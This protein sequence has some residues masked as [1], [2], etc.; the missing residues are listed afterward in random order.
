MPALVVITASLG[1]YRYV[2]RYILVTWSVV[3]FRCGERRSGGTVALLQGRLCIINGLESIKSDQWRDC[4]SPR[5]GGTWRRAVWTASAAVV[6]AA[7]STPVTAANRP[8]G[9]HWSDLWLP[10]GATD[11]TRWLLVADGRRP[12]ERSQLP[13]AATTTKRRDGRFT[14]T[15][16]FVVEVPRDTCDVI[17]ADDV[18][19]DVTRV[20]DVGHD[21]HV[22]QATQSTSGIH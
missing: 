8:A 5:C 9:R 18:T 7:S 14:G 4:Q 16:C 22:T 6:P 12:S 1:R 19:C 17:A 11:C 3:G 2:G 10:A 21:R 15:R 13:A 20:A